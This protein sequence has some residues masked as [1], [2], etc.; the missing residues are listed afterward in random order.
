M[1]EATATTRP[2]RKRTTA[3]KATPAKAATPKTAET[4]A[5]ESTELQKFVVELEQIEDTKNFARFV[6]PK[7]SGCVGTFYAPLGTTQ[8]RVQIAGPAS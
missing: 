7:S 1:A 4:P 8:V 2:A 3:S 6:P 5:E